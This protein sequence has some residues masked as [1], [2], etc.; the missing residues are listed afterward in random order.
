M[1]EKYLS[2]KKDVNMCIYKVIKIIWS[3]HRKG[4]KHDV[5]NRISTDYE[6]HSVINSSEM[7]VLWEHICVVV[8]V[9]KYVLYF[10]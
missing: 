10:L 5:N 4:L 8:V 9:T 1:S 7:D 6:Y 3:D 2:I